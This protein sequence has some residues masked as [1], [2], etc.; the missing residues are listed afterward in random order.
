M[1]HKILIIDDEAGFTKMVK[2]NLEASGKY[3]VVIENN[4]SR[5]LATAIL[6]QPDLILLDIIMP[7]VEGGEVKNILQNHY[8]TSRIPVIFLTATIRKEE[9]AQSGRAGGHTF[10]AKPTSI[11]EL[12]VCIDSQLKGQMS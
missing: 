1:K 8:Y 11:Q 2:L 3:E 4:S 9:A 10:M 12:T 5:A 6:T 7:G